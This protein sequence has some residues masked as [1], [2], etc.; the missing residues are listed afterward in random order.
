M[1]SIDQGLPPNYRTVLDVVEEAGRG[2]HVT[3]QDIWVRARALQ[4]RIGFATV[5][6]GLIRLHELG[7]VMKIDVP[8]GASAVY[9]PAASPHA[10]FRCTGCGAITDLEYAVPPHIVR[11]LAERH[12]VAIEGEAVTFTGR[13]ADCG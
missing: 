10:H 6:R 9:E 7:A 1:S 2:S 4:P 11:R 3:A 13:C 8:G 12:G 5:H